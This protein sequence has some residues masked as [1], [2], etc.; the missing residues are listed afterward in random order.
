MAKLKR[1]A[2]KP[3]L[4]VPRDNTAGRPIEVTVLHTSTQITLK[5][6][7]TATRLAKDLAAGVRGLVLQV[8]PYPLSLEN[9]HVPV[10]FT[11]ILFLELAERANVEL[12]V[13]IRIGRDKVVMLESAI[14]PNSVV[15]IGGRHGWWLTPEIRAAKRLGCSVIDKF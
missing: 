3:F 1:T 10:E 4:P 2:S 9:P 5:A 12:R 11:Q 6:V 8:V 14:Q 7:E 13:D 15:V